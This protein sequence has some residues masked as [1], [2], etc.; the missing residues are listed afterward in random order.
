[1]AM[2]GSRERLQTY[3]SIDVTCVE[4][5]TYWSIGELIMTN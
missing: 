1:M 4:S 2:V 5:R 3:Q